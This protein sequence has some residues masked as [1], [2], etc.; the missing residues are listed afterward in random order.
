[1]QRMTTLVA[2]FAMAFGTA[3]TVSALAAI[4]VGSRN[5]TIS[6]AGAEAGGGS[7]SQKAP[8]LFSAAFFVLGTAFF[9]ASL[10]DTRPF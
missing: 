7:W 8:A 10:H 5:L 9:F 6:I 2:T 1:M 3:L 4:S